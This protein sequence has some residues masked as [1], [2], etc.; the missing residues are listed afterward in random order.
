M[1][2]LEEA[3]LNGMNCTVFMYGQTGAGKTHTLFGPPNFSLMSEE[4]WGICPRFLSNMLTHSESDSSM[5]LRASAVELYFNDCNDLLNGKAKVPI[6][7]AQSKVKS[8]SSL[9]RVP[10]YGNLKSTNF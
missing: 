8:S 4:E 6:V 5:K 10:S 1:P 9:A 3:F 7:G 2:S